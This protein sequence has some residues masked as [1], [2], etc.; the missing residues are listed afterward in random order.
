MHQG[1]ECPR[2]R[3][4]ALLPLVLWNPLP[5]AMIFIHCCVGAGRPGPLGP[6]RFVRPIFSLPASVQGVGSLLY[7]GTCSSASWSSAVK[8]LFEFSDFD[9]LLELLNTL[10]YA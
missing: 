2:G 4:I 10:A 6:V 1:V 3:K 9:G 8:A 5:F 7:P